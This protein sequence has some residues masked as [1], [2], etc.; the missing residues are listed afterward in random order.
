VLAYGDDLDTIDRRLQ[1][2]TDAFTSLVE[3]T[4]K[5]RFELNIKKYK[6]HKTLQLE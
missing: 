6:N 3:Q 4:N 2:L 5:N 1:E